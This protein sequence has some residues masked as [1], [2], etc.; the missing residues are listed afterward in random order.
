MPFRTRLGRFLVDET[1][2]SA[3]RGVRECSQDASRLVVPNLES[4]EQE[5][6]DAAFCPREAGPDPLIGR[7]LEKLIS[8]G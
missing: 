1:R 8:G 5:Q 6:P 3:R 4:A 2:T 7:G